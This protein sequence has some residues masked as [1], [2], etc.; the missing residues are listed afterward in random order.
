MI[1]FR[2]FL[3]WPRWAVSALCFALICYLTL[4]PDPLP[5]ND[6]PFWEHTDKL[7]HAIMFG[8]MYVCLFLD[9][10]RG[11]MPSARASWLITLPVA[12]FG[13]LVELAQQFMGMGRGGD[14][15][16]FA[17]DCLGI[18]LAL[19]LTRCLKNL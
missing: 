6:I 5:D 17:A 10:W 19:L 15:I 8:A 11:K 16:D 1:F 7:V 2:F 3:K 9:I 14:V 13:G 4:F 12:A 18:I